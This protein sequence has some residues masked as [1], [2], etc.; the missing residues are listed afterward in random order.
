VRRAT[1]V[2]LGL[3]FGFAGCSDLRDF[4]GTWQGPRVGDAAVLRVGVPARTNLTLAV[5]TVDAHGMTGRLTVDGLIAETEFQS[6][7]GA[8]AGVLSGMSFAGSHLRVYLTFVPVPDN[9]GQALAL[10]A[11][12]NERRIEVRVLRGGPTPVYAIFALTEAP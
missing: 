3:I 10:I 8:E 9:A 6:L 4:R 5:D 12:Y 1:F 2:L 7:A 11:L